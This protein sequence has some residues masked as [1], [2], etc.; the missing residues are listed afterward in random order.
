MCVLFLITNLGLAE[1]K[2]TVST[3]IIL[4]QIYLRETT[5]VGGYALLLFA[6]SIA[7]DHDHAIITVDGWI[8]FN[9]P[10]RAAV[11]FKVCVVL[12]A[13][14]VKSVSACTVLRCMQEK[15]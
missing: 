11:L 1:T 4:L 10:V 5:M 13:P 9:A 8:D 6:G 15:M 12:S 3:L 14:R 7:V 2:N